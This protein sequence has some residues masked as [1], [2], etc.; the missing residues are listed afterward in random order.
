MNRKLWFVEKLRRNVERKMAILAM[1][2]MMKDSCP[3]PR[4]LSLKRQSGN[5]L[6]ALLRIIAE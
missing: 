4:S 2:L 5:C 1:N 6:A 3:S